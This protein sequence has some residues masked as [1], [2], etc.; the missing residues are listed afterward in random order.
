MKPVIASQNKKGGNLK[1]AFVKLHFHSNGEAIYFNVT[2][3]DS[4]SLPYHQSDAGSVI[5]ARSDPDGLL[6]SETPEQVIDEIAKV[7]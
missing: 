3:I 1:M 2:S 6:V 4:I 7:S 5:T